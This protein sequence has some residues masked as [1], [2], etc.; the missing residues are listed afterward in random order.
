M[1]VLFDQILIVKGSDEISEWDFDFSEV[2][3]HNCFAV[4]MR[5]VAVFQ[6]TIIES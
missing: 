6:R 4:K 3:R 1:H 2:V 5:H